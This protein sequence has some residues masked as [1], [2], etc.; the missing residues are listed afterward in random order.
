MIGGNTDRYTTQLA[1]EFLAAGELSRR[2]FPV[3]TIIGNAKFV[4]IIA[5]TSN[6][7]IRIDAKTGGQ[8]ATGQLARNL[9][10]KT[11]TM[12]LFI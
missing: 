11:H 10:I 6:G 2:G 5:S 1:G 9:W 7:E 4:G 8:R 3:S 12:F